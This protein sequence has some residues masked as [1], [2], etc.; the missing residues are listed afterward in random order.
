MLVSTDPTDKVIK[1]GPLEWDGVTAFTPPANRQL[2]TET[3]AISQ[4]YSYPPPSAAEV[5]SAALE[6]RA[7]AALAANATYLAITTPTQAQV[8]AQTARLTRQ[9]NALI[10]LLLNQTDITSG[11]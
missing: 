5:N 8:V 6:Q 2:I 7:V 9:A 10:R 11:T 4:G 3:A 1:D